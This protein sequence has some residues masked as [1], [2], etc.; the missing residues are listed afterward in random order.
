MKVDFEDLRIGAPFLFHG[1]L[2]HKIST[3]SGQGAQDGFLNDFRGTAVDLLRDDAETIGEA[4]SALWQE[5]FH[6]YDHLYGGDV[7]G[8]IAS[9]VSK[10]LEKALVAQL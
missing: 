1:F 4:T 10:A 3:T 6:Q 9:Q 5:M 2:F 8:D 7:A